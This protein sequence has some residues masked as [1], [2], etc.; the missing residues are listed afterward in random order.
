MNTSSKSTLHSMNGSVP[1]TISELSKNDPM[2]NIIEQH[3]MNSAVL[4]PITSP[5]KEDVRMLRAQAYLDLPTTTEAQKTRARLRLKEGDRG[6]APRVKTGPIKITKIEVISNPFLEQRYREYKQKITIEAG[7]KTL[8]KIKPTTTHFTH[9]LD[10]SIGEVF[11]FHGTSNDI[12]QKIAEGGFRPDLSSN[13]GSAE[14]P[15]YGA[16]GQGTYFS[17]SMGKVISYTQDPYLL[18]YDRSSSVESLVVISSVILGVPK[19]RHPFVQKHE[20]MRRDGIDNIKN[21]RHSVVSRGAQAY[22]I[23]PFKISSGTNEFLLKKAEAMN[24]KYIVHFKHSH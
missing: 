14:K 1:C 20:H 13:H 2:Y 16:L 9:G 23:N 24:P 22:G 21:N 17:D 12:V 18:D 19:F 11:L 4:K 15:R 3:L 7:Q 6:G 10:Q 5:K 8:E